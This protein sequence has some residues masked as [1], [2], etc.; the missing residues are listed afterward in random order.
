MDKPKQSKALKKT[1]PSTPKLQSAYSPSTTRIQIFQS[2]EKKSSQD[3]S[4]KIEN[5]IFMFKNL[6]KSLEQLYS[7][8]SSENISAFTQGASDTLKHSL[9]QFQ[10]LI[11]KQQ[12]KNTNIDIADPNE[13]VD[14]EILR[15]YI[16]DGLQPTEALIL[17]IKEKAAD[18][19]EEMTEEEIEEESEFDDEKKSAEIGSKEETESWENVSLLSLDSDKRCRSLSPGTK[20]HINQL[21]EKLIRIDRPSPHEIKEKSEIR[22]KRAECKRNL[23]KIQRQERAIQRKRKMRKVREEVELQEAEKKLAIELQITL[24]QVKADERYEAH[25][26]SIRNRAKSENLKTSEAAFILELQAEDKKLS[27]E[28]KKMTLDNRISETRERRA[29]VLENVKQ[30]QVDRS[31]KEEAAEKRR[32]EIQNEKGIKYSYLQQKI[33]EA[34]NRRNQILEVKKTIAEELS[35]KRVIR[36]RTVK[37]KPR[38]IKSEHSEKD[39]ESWDSELHSSIDEGTG[40]VFKSWIT[41]DEKEQ[42]KE[43]VEVEEIPEACLWCSVCNYVL[44]SGVTGQEHMFSE[45][46]RLELNR[47][48]IQGNTTDSVIEISTGVDLSV[49]RE[50]YVKKRVKKIKQLYNSRCLKHEKASIMGKEASS[51]NKN[52]LQ[53]L[54]LDL[55]K[56]ITNIIDYE[57]AESVLKDTIKLLDQRKEADLHVIRQLKFIPCIMEIV[58]KVWSC[59]KHEVKYVLR[60]LETITRFLTI[61]SGLSENRTY[62]EVTNRL[63]PLIDLISWIL[64]K[65]LKEMIELNYV[66]QLFHLFTILLKHRLPPEHRHFKD[67]FV[68]YLLNSGILSKLKQK[69]TQLQGPLDLTSN[70]FSLLLLKCVG[71]LESLTTFPGWGLGDKPAYEVSIFLTENFLYLLQ[72][73]ELAG[74]PYLLLCLLLNENPAKRVAPKVI[75]QTLLAVAILSTRFLNNLARLHLPLLQEMLSSEEYYDNIYHLFDYILRYCTEHLDTGPEDVRELLHEVILLI[76]YFVSM[77][78]KNQDMMKL[79]ETSVIQRLCNLPFG[80]FTDKKYINVLFP[81]L[82]AICYEHGHNYS[83]LQHEM[84]VDLLVNYIKQQSIVYA[85]DDKHKEEHKSE[86]RS[87]RSLS[88]S[89]SNSYSKSILAAASF[90]LVFLN[91]FPRNLWESAVNFF[92]SGIETN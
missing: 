10:L 81:T 35:K 84:S 30:K 60:L 23:T 13:S 24:K 5:W 16:N 9:D 90:K 44:T 8:C 33:E 50:L 17:L 36:S 56:C 29:K 3:Y 18:D 70:N 27:L 58:K 53:K 77:N 49:Q 54:S 6:N 88:I 65:T 25:L 2:T 86:T 45:K 1:P 67:Y 79:G 75:P 14:G 91:R 82:I 61:F 64:N 4:A 40:Q 73:S 85:A 11:S 7:M 80:Y 68:E 15:Q 43:K 59:P 71:F 51:V 92:S 87:N 74:I 34:E 22:Q 55:D 32:Q 38:K 89:S 21:K 28:E 83:I 72:E 76:G 12:E 52:R 69:L 78:H 62:L 66:P 26:N 46:H 47:S 42:S 48:L 31:L 20:Q 41:P 37:K 57:T 39:D 19:L 63:I